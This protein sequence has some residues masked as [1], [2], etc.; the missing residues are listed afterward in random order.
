MSRSA[1]EMHDRT[2]PL[3][4]THTGVCGVRPHWRNLDDRQIRAIADSG[5]VVGIIF[6]GNFLSRSGG[7]RNVDMV[8]EHLEHVLKVGGAECP[9]IGTDFD[10]AIS[11]P[12]DIRSA[13]GYACL[14]DALLRRGHPVEVVEGILGRNFLMSFK[15]LRPGS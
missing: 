12:S 15:R 2:L 5:G 7:P 1:V 13:H 8:V 6:A 4:A 14:V 10:G 11:P 9:A 3:I